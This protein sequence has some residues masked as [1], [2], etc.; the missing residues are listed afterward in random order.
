ME[1]EFEITRKDYLDF[2]T[3]HFF[4]HQVGSQIITAVAGFF[5][6]IFLIFKDRTGINLLTLLFLGVFYFSCYGLYIFFWLLHTKNIPQ[7]KGS[8]LGLKKLDFT[9]EAINFSDQ[10]SNGSYKWATIM[11][12]AETKKAFYLYC[13][14]NMAI[15]VPKR[16]FTDSSKLDEFRTMLKRRSL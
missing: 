14:S 15:V 11:N 12:T 4:K 2:S 1:V 9:E 16:V 5:L 6:F 7:D 10:N 13:D 8:I 3:Y